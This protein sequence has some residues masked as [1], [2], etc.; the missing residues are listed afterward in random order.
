MI[1]NENDRDLLKVKLQHKGSSHQRTRRGAGE[2][3]ML[4]PT[5]LLQ[6]LCNS[7]IIDLQ[8]SASSKRKNDLFIYLRT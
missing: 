4:S 8:P 7:E 1:N 2:Y 6:R 5:T 3:G